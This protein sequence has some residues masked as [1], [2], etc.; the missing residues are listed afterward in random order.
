MNCG[1]VGAACC[2]SL[3]SIVGSTLDSPMGGSPMGGGVGG[4]A[5]AAGQS[6]E[7][8]PPGEAD[9]ESIFISVSV[10]ED[11]KVTVNNKPTVSEGKTRR[12][13]IRALEPGK[14]YKFVV[15][16]ETVNVWGIAMEDTKTVSLTTGTRE[17]MVLTPVRN[18]K[19]TDASAKTAEDVEAVPADDAKQS[20]TT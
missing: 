9:W 20:P 6:I 18:R 14:K 3:G 10:P 17:E 4:V 8:T 13:V 19:K 1:S 16:A 2:D 5:G 7:P 15:R 12:F 11:A